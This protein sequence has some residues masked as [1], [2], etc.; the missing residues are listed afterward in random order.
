MQAPLSRGY[1]TLIIPRHGFSGGVWAFVRPF[2]RITPIFFRGNTQ[3]APL[4]GAGPSP[5][6]S[7]GNSRPPFAHVYASFFLGEHLSHHRM[8]EGP[9]PLLYG[10]HAGGRAETWPGPLPS[11]LPPV[12]P[13]GGAFNSV[14]AYQT[15]LARHGLR[16]KASLRQNTS[17]RQWQSMVSA[18]V[19]VPAHGACVGIS[20]S[21]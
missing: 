19:R 9:S 1:I 17:Q 18:L 6:S 10:K 11:N 13:P 7:G 14:P 2:A 8:R 20:A 3:G 4:P 15:S 21:A 12:E 5:P 16:S